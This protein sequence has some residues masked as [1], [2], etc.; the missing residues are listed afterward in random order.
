MKLTSLMAERGKAPGKHGVQRRE[1]VGVAEVAQIPDLL[2]A[3]ALAGF[4]HHADRAPVVLVGRFLNHRPP[5]ALA[6]RLYAKL[7]EVGVVLVQQRQVAGEGQ[8]IDPVAKSIELV[9]ALVTTPPKGVKGGF[10][11]GYGH[12]E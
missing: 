11:R 10:C 12:R 3:V 6:H 1:V 7:R 8:E 4:Q 5:N 9:G 2:D